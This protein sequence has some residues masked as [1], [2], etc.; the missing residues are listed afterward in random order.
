MAKNAE[1]WSTPSFGCR[2]CVTIFWFS[3]HFLLCGNALGLL[4][5]VQQRALVQI[6]QDLGGGLYRDLGLLQIGIGL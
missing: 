6:G 3:R 2:D 5:Q 4:Q 1:N